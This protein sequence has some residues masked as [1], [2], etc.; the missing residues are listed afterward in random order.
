MK[1]EVYALTAY[2]YKTKQKTR[3]TTVFEAAKHLNLNENDIAIAVGKRLVVG[4]YSFSM[5]KMYP[6]QTPAPH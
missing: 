1:I 5:E 6:S 3:F 2:N 4:D